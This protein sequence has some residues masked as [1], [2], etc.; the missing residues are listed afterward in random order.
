MGVVRNKYDTGESFLKDHLPDNSKT[1]GVHNYT[2][3]S[4]GY[5]HFS[6]NGIFQGKM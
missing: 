5:S 3:E 6:R 4:N 1:T 2:I